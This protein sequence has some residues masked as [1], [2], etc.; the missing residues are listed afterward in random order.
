[1]CIKSKLQTIIKNK[2]AIQS[3]LGKR[4]LCVLAD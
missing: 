3:I 1:M 4:K 2:Q